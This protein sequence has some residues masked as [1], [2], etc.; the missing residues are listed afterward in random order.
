MTLKQ[1]LSYDASKL[2]FQKWLECTDI[3]AFIQC[4]DV[5]IAKTGQQFA[6]YLNR[7]IKHAGIGLSWGVCTFTINVLD[8]CTFPS[9]ILYEN[10]LALHPINADNKRTF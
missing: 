9:L 2:V 8:G 1:I 7:V 6:F 10:K 5:Q 3:S 4:V